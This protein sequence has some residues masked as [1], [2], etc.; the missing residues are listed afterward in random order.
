[1]HRCMFMAGG[2]LAAAM[3][4]TAAEA[5]TLRPLTTLKA[6]VVRLSDL[7]DDAGPLAGHVLGPAP[8][9]GERI[10]VGARQ[11]AAIARM[12]GVAWQ[13]QSGAD[14]AVLERPGRVLPRAMVLDALRAALGGIGAPADYDVHLPG[15]VAPMV[16]QQG[17]LEV[18]VEQLDYNAD[19]ARFSATLIVIA[20]GMAPLR[21]R[22]AGR[23]DEMAELPVPTHRLPAGSV[24]RAEDLALVRVR[25]G[26]LHGPVAHSPA[27]VIGMTLR[28][29][30]E[31]RAPL[32]LADLARAGTVEKGTPVVLQVETG[33]LSATT[34][35]IALATGAPG[36]RIPVLNPLSRMVVQGEVL[37][38]GVIA[39]APGSMPAPADAHG[40]AALP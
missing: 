33:G 30:A 40:P 8:A 16:S 38:S 22:V 20:E 12:F 5:A 27:E 35:G 31:P 25:V 36:E 21:L 37:P 9:P 39:V 23:A 3:L 26:A 34:Q 28:R 2:L 13:P 24:P 14:A 15:F 4:P 1:M 7:F 17:H 11:L 32:P 10:V 19:S 6:P 18:S 29:P